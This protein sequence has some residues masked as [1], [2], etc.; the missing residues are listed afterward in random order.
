VLLPKAHGLVNPLR[1]NLN[2]SII[3]DLIEIGLDV[4]NLQQPRALGIEDAG[5]QADLLEIYFLS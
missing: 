4:I 1:C 2:F 3:E 5:A